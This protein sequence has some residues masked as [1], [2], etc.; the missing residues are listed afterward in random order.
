MSIKKTHLNY[1]KQ[2]IKNN[3]DGIEIVNGVPKVVFIFWFSNTDYTPEFTVRR[4]NALRSLVDNLK[5]PVIIITNDN[6]KCWEVPQ[7]PIHEGFKYLSGNHKSDYLRAYILCHYGGGYHDIKWREKSWENEWDKFLNPNIWV[8]GRRELKEDYI[9]YNPEKDEK[10]VQQEFNKLVTMG[11]VI[12]KPY[13][14]Y[15]QTLINKINEKLDSKIEILKLKP[16]PKSRCG[17]GNGCE[18][19]EYTLRWLELMGEIFHPLLLNY[20]SHIDFTLPDILYKIYK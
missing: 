16:A 4:F 6:L 11:W 12:S 9:A 3:L 15:I 8:I 1:L 7:Y 13:N 14:E 19:N 5:V 20:T 17:V 18:E 10:W 2:F